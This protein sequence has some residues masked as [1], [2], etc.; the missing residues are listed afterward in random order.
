MAK[1]LYRINIST[2]KELYEIIEEKSKL[3]VR[4][5][6]SVAKYYLIKGLEA[7]GVKDIEKLSQ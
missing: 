2:N 4:S 5:I 6:A 1:R 7:E 3:E